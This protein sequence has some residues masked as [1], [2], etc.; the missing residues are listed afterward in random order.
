MLIR[1]LKEQDNGHR[2]ARVLV[3]QVG[4]MFFAVVVTLTASSWQDEKLRQPMA[5]VASIFSTVFYLFLVFY[6]MRE[7]GSRDSVKIAGGRLEYAPAYGFKIGLLATAPNYVF[8]LLM[9]LGLVLGL[10]VDASG[11]LMDTAGRG[12]WSTGYTI[13]TM[14]QSM[15]SG[16]LR[17]LFSDLDSYSGVVGATIA[18]LITPLFGPLASFVGYI[19]GCKRPMRVKS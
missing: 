10:E 13:T 3:N 9:V 14:L 16:V 11:A 8:V 7:E 2:V 12:V 4:M 5:L 1:F 17:T 15:Y 18:Y 6:A 19:H